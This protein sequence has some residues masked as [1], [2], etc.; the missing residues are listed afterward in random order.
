MGKTLIYGMQDKDGGVERFV[1]NLSKYGLGPEKKYGYIVLGNST[2]F[3]DE[4]K[5]LGVD[6]F[7]VTHKNKSLIKNIA[8]LQRVLKT[9]R[10]E[11]DQI[12]FNSSGIFY[13]IPFIFALLNN[14]RIVIHSHSA[15]CQ[16][17][18]KFIHL[19]N[20]GWINFFITTRL[21][22]STAAGRFM[23][24]NAK[25]TVIPNAIDIDKF[26]FNENDKNMIR[27]K[28]GISHDDLLIGNIGRLTKVKNQ[29]FLI[30]MFDE[31]LKVNSKS[32]CIIVG[33][34]EDLEL[35]KDKCQ[36]KKLEGKVIFTGRV[37]NPECFLSALDCLVMP[38]IVEGFPITLV[39][40]QANGLPCVVSKNITQEVN[41]SGE[42]RFCSLDCIDDW[43]KN[44]TSNFSR[45]DCVEQ[46][47]IK[48]FDVKGI[49][50]L[51][52]NY[53]CPNIK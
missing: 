4:F 20:R 47:K 26:I 35:L 1:V 33:D 43:I 21:A 18:K 5:K 7:F 31:L 14:Y 37:D 9:Q 8:E 6:Y 13:P 22:C 2:I 25:F 34:G 12:Y 42:I 3:E 38:S 15:N 27:E 49:E 44:I 16:W 19:V 52:N 45:Y 24:G 30:E 29:I 36:E 41:I 50:K 48:G 17:P 40:A 10:K 28:Y 51:V 46:L 32:K 53:L 11:Y 23:F 39:E